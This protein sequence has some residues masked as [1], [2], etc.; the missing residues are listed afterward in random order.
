MYLELGFSSNCIVASSWEPQC[1]GVGNEGAAA[2]AKVPD[3]RRDAPPPALTSRRH[4][5]AIVSPN[6]NNRLTTHV[7]YWACKK[8][9]SSFILSSVSAIVNFI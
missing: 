4:R 8:L 9:N 3:R 5:D 7:W 2:A 6:V 1:R